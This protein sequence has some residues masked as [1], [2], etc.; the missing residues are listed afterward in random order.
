MSCDAGID[1][2][3]IL[4]CCNFW[5][6]FDDLILMQVKLVV[7]AGGS[8]QA[9]NPGDIIYP[10]LGLAERRSSKDGEGFAPDIL[11]I[12]Y[13]ASITSVYLSF[14]WITRGG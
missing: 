12:D 10:V 14:L 4:L 1:I 5:L 9:T 13:N 3:R 6:E 11:L 2:S 8:R 7:E